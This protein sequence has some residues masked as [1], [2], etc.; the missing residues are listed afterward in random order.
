MAYR[1]DYEKKNI[2]YWTQ[3]TDG[4]SSVNQG[5]LTSHQHGV[6][7][8]VLSEHIQAHFPST[9]PQNI[10]VL[11][12]GTGPGFFAIILTELGYRVTAI[13]YTASM[14]KAAKCNAGKLADK[15]TFLQ[16]NAEQLAF[17]DSSFDVLVSRNLTWNL[18]NPDTAYHHWNRVL[19][20]GGLLLNFDANW[21]SYLHNEDALQ[22]HLQDRENIRQTGVGD[23]TE[24]TDVAAMEAIARQA[25][26]S[27]ICRPAWDIEILNSLAMQTTADEKIW[28]RVWTYEERINNTSTPMFLVKAE[29]NT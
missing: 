13:D 1:T 4:Y 29:K 15:I 18:R 24:G 9:A 3:R 5:E 20:P 10:H 23:E 11:D 27:R 19:K 28:Q 22:G 17:P 26:L 12:V 6:W 14:L 2:T 7:S 21:Y 25:P 16:M 8:K